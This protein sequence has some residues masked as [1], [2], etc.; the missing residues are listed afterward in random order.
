MDDNWTKYQ[1]DAYDEKGA[2][3]LRQ[4]PQLLDK[5][6]NLFQTK[7]VDI[8]TKK[9]KKNAFH[10]G[11]KVLCLIIIKGKIE[12]DNKIDIV[13]NALIPNLTISQLK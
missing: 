5:L 12:E 8:V 1:N 9:E 11:L 4:D 6:L 13:K 3:F 10:L 7:I 2:T